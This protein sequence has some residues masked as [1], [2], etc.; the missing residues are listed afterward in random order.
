MT[1]GTDSPGLKEMLEQLQESVPVITANAAKLPAAGHEATH[2][3]IWKKT[4]LDQKVIYERDIKKQLE[5]PL[6]ATTHRLMPKAGKKRVVLLGESVARGYFYDPA[7]S[8]AMELEHTLNGI[9]EM[10]GTEVIDLARTSLYIDELVELTHTCKALQPDVVVIFAGNNFASKLGSSLERDDYREMFR[11]FKKE[12]FAG[13]KLYL[14]K[15]FEDIIAAFLQKV[16]CNLTN[17]G[18]PVVLVVPGF[19][20][21]D[22]KSDE[23]EKSIC[24]SAV[25]DVKKWLDARSQAIEAKNNDDWN[26]LCNAAS[27]MVDADPSNPLGYELLAAYYRKKGKTDDAIAMLELARDTVIVSRGN[28]SKPRC[29]EVIRKSLLSMAPGYNMETVDLSLIFRKVFPGKVP[30]KE[31]Y[32]DYCHLTIRGIKT[33]MRFTAQRV[34]E[35]LTGMKMPVSGI[36][37]SDLLPDNMVQAAAH[38]CAAIHNAHYGQQKDVLDYHCIQAVSFSK[39]IAIPMQQFVHFSTRKASSIVCSA[40]EEII[41][42]GEMR[43]YEGGLALP[44]PRGKKL[45][46]IALVDAVTDALAS[47][48]IN[49]SEEVNQMRQNEHGVSTEKMNLLESFYSMDSYNEFNKGQKPVFYQARNISSSFTFIA[50]KTGKTICNM[51]YRTAGNADVNEAVKFFLNDDDTA[52]CE[53]PVS[54]SWKNAVF[55]LDEVN[56]RNGVNTIRVEWPFTAIEL[57]EPLLK[58]A[59]AFMDAMF[60]VLG[61]IYTFDIVAGNPHITAG[62]EKFEAE[63]IYV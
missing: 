21:A 34:T 58:S 23:T 57:K 29:F 43:Q 63:L 19:N 32:L 50:G 38:F 39:N 20:L 46:D 18:I 60:P 13:I 6:W 14:E 59:D 10:D 5:W 37:E 24:S 54:S 9:K 2:I 55:E 36:N 35:I 48:G 40:F 26:T 53:L 22:W 28:N 62:K 4:N 41:M 30:G 42:G 31:L 25:A 1:G 61:E 49:I 33:A 17:S 56:L 27:I 16:H 12:A 7:Y 45:M 3:G 52:V 11:L 15:K 47:I 8:V 51:V 44:N